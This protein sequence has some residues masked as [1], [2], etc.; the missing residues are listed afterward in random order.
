MRNQVAS[1]I[2]KC[3][4]IWKKS[5]SMKKSVLQM[6]N[7]VNEFRI[8]LYIVPFFRDIYQ[9]LNHMQQVNDKLVNEVKTV[10]YSTKV[11]TSSTND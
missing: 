3:Q 8:I 6:L 1:I 4:F 9:L 5:M 2:C 11:S 7:P 10:D